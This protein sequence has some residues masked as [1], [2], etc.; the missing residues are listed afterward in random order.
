MRYDEARLL[1]LADW[2]TSGW[3]RFLPVEGQLLWDVVCDATSHGLE[4][5]LDALVE[6]HLCLRHST[7]DMDA[8]DILD[9]PLSRQRRRGNQRRLESLFASNGHTFPRTAREMAQLGVELG[10]YLRYR[11]RQVTYWRAPAALPLP[12]EVLIMPDGQRDRED[13]YRWHMAGGHSASKIADLIVES[14]RGDN[15]VTSIGHLATCL[16]ADPETVRQGLS[17]LGARDFD[18]PRQRPAVRVYVAGRSNTLV[19]MTPERLHEDDPCVI[20]PFWRRLR[21]EYGRTDPSPIAS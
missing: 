15:M 2:N 21:R 20:V 12:S 7:K 5:E 11:R 8:A 10:L 9:A 14:C 17:H 4:G 3:C 18:K 16:A 1:S 6:W 13:A 19:S